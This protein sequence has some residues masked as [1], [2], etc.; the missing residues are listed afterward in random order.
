MSKY[1]LS[2]MT[3]AVNY[4]VYAMVGDMPSIRRKILIHGGAS[5]P[6]EKSGFGEMS[7]DA[8]GRP[9]WTADGVVTPVSDA[10]YELLKENHVFKQHLAANVVKVINH[11][12]TG[13][14]RE[15]SKNVQHM[16][17]DGFRQLTPST[18]KQR[19]KVTQGSQ[20]DE[21]DFRL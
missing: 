3:A 21:N 13:S 19:I 8:D 18:I 7:R 11:D 14:Q 5:I 6:S 10:D 12:I 16:S 1:I 15:I 9:I 4:C 2:T 20:Q 17:E